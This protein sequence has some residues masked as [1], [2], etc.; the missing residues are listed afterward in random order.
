MSGNPCLILEWSDAEEWP[1][2]HGL[3]PNALRPGPRS[4]PQN[5]KPAVMQPNRTVAEAEAKRLALAHPGKRF[6]VFEATHIA[7][8]VDV[9][10]HVTVSGNI[11]Q[12]RK[13]P[14]LLEIDDSEIPF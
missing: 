10:S 1:G 12:S 2:L 3:T 6:A 14:A 9:P 4:I 7:M 5:R 11:W 13:M 8:T